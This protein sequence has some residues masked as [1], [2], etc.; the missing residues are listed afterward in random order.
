MRGLI[1]MI[2]SKTANDIYIGCT[3][4]SLNIRR[5]KHIYDSKKIKRMKPIHKYINDNGGWT[6]YNFEIIEEKEYE[7]L[8]DLREIEKQFIK[9]YKDND[10]YS[11]LN[12]RK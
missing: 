10:E 6:N 8:K 3:K 2:R 5:S 7:T 4:Q 11:L 12:S 9:S 1:Y